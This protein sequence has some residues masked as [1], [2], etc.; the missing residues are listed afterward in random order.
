[1]KAVPLSDD[2]IVVVSTP[3]LPPTS[4]PP[5]V[6]NTPGLGPQPDSREFIQ[7][8]LTLGRADALI[9]KMQM[10]W[11]WLVMAEMRWVQE[12]VLDLFSQRSRL[13]H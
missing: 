5:S 3:P 11:N 4:P 1:M 13:L 2:D 8:L 7:A 10:E 9:Q 6:P 12:K